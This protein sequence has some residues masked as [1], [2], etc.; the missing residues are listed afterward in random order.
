MPVSAAT[1]LLFAAASLAIIAT[2][3]PTMLLALSNGSAQGLRFAAFGMAGAALSDLLLIGAVSLGLGAVLA[4]S[5][6]LFAALQLAGIAYLAWLALQFWQ[7]APQAL[8][9]APPQQRMTRG[10]AFCRSLLVALS[11]PK[12]LLFLSAFLPQFID[13][14]RPQAPQYLLL[15]I[16]FTTLDLALMACYAAGGVQAAR[17]LSRNG[18]R[19]LHRGSAAALL[20]LAGLL[21]AYRRG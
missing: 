18:M 1:L 14:A 3:G 9:T 10:R 6:T 2:P 19:K 11:N 21:A 13:T 8:P 7:A 15:A 20:V 16:L 4:A 17:L 12:G 5:N